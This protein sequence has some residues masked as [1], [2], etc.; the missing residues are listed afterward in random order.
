MHRFQNFLTKATLIVPWHLASLSNATH[1][2]QLCSSRDSRGRSRATN[3]ICIVLKYFD[4]HEKT[5]LCIMNQGLQIRYALLQVQLLLQ[6]NTDSKINKLA[7]L[8]RCVSRVHFGQWPHGSISSKF[9]HHMAPLSLVPNL[10][11]KWGSTLL[12]HV[13]LLSGCW[14]EMRWSL[15]KP[16]YQYK[17]I[18]TNGATSKFGTRWRHLH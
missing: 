18:T 3:K 9:G 14:D 4:K 13:S 7:K 1:L 15:H 11:T 12:Y 6:Y 16:K 5:N 17:D 2:K 10:S 8:R